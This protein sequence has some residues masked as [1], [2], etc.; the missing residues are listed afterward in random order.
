MCCIM[1][2]HKCGYG[3]TKTM[4]A[5]SNPSQSLPEKG[6]YG[7]VYVLHRSYAYIAMLLSIENFREF[8]IS[9]TEGTICASSNPCH[10]IPV[11]GMYTA[12]M[13]FKIFMVLQ[14][15]AYFFRLL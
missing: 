6:K 11:N 15:H 2:R 1:F 12:C 9:S 3:Q 13:V 4:H 5:C 8:R 7:M 14:S 10:S